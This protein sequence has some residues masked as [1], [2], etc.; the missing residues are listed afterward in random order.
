MIFATVIA[1]F[2]QKSYGNLSFPFFIALVVSYMLKDRI[3]EI[4]RIYFSGKLGRILY[5]YKTY[6]RTKS[7]GEIGWCK[8]LFCFQNEP[9][10]PEE[11]IKLRNKDH[12][13][14]IEND[15][16]GEQVILYKKLIKLYTNDFKNVILKIKGIE[17]VTQVISAKGDAI[18][19]LYVKLEDEEM[20]TPVQDIALNV[21]GSSNVTDMNYNETIYTDISGTARLKLD[22]GSFLLNFAN[23]SSSVRYKLP[24]A[25]SVDLKSPGTTIITI[26][27]EKQ[28]EINQGVVEIEV[29]GVDNKPVN[30]LLLYVN[31]PEADTYSPSGKRYSYTNSEGIA[32]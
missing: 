31:D 11:I 14:D 6:L 15:W 21:T 12:I 16:M 8:E 22:K 20:N 1:F 10:V 26:N 29:F 27:L 4:L 5:N 23:N 17:K 2:T 25:F 3:K 28:E 18:Y 13:T 32:S 9:E 24:D 7:H 30:N 19:T